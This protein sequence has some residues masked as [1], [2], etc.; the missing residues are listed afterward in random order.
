[1]ATRIYL[2]DIFENR[3]HIDILDSKA[4]IRNEL[5]HIRN[6][7]EFCFSIMCSFMILEII[8]LFVSLLTL[9]PTT[10]LIIGMILIIFAI[11]SAIGYCGLRIQETILGSRY[12]MLKGAP[13]K[14]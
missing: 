5:E 9:I 14:K 10:L 3:E 12:L 7:R 11:L 4:E 13:S 1:M 2:D 8:L 6:E